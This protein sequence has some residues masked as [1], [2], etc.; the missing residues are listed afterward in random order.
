[1]SVE[2]RHFLLKKSVKKQDGYEW[3]SELQAGMK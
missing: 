3:R 1:M 2:F